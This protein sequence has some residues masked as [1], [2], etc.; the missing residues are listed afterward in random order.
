MKEY[1]FIVLGSDQN[2]YGQVRAINEFT[3]KKV[4]VV[5]QSLFSATKYSKITNLYLYSDLLD[6]D[7]FVEHLINLYQEFNGSKV[8]LLLLPCGDTYIELLSRNQ[9]AL[10]DYYTFPVNN[11]ELTTQLTDKENFIKVADQYGLNH[12]KSLIVTP[13]TSEEIDFDQIGGQFPVA[14]KAVDSVKWLDI[15][16]PGRKK[17][18]VLNSREEVYQTIKAARAA[19]YNENFILQEYIP[20][21]ASTDRVLN[22]YVDQ[23]HHVK[24]MNLGHPLLEDPSP[25]S[26]GNYLVI[27]PEYN[28][29]LY[30][31]VKKFLEAIKYTGF[32][33]FDLKLDPRDHQYK[34]FEI[35]L[36]FGRSSFYVNLNGAS[37]PKL[38]LEDYFEG[39]MKNQPL[40]Y[41]NDDSKKHVLWTS[42]PKSIFQKYVKHDPYYFEATELIN[43]KAYGDTL[44]YDPDLSLKRKLMIWHMN[45]YYR[46][47]FKKYGK[48]PESQNK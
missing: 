47:T 29:E 38:L 36:R 42:V 15:D 11:Y 24:M 5:A 48:I 26:I 12:P 6:D 44:T 21:G 30:Q 19:G 31:M 1:R 16:F 35:N 20:G 8:M 32:A 39:S 27:L 2:A 4:D 10:K 14:L 9:N 33:N 3:H 18:F 7:K 41:C 45:S 17:A 43:R 23:Y 13:D 28:L 25:G 37:F 46:K 34:F 22:C 40:H